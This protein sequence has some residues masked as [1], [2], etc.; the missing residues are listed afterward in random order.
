MNSRF[1]S[2]TQWKIFLLVSGYH[3][4]AH[5]DGNNMAS[6]YKALWIWVNHFSRY[7]TYEKLHWPVSLWASLHIYL[8]S[9]PRFWTSSIERFWVLFLM[10]W[11]WEPAKGMGSGD[12]TK[13]IFVKLWGCLAYRSLKEQG[14]K[15]RLLEISPLVQIGGKV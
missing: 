7:L 8:L 5:P 3:V 12:V 2:K 6:S 11:Q 4:G 10:A 1:R 15:V 9:F 13:T 14:E